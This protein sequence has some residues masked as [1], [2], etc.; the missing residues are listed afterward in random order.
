MLLVPKFREGPVIPWTPLSNLELDTCNA[1]ASTTSETL[2]KGSITIKHG[3]IG[4]WA[5]AFRRNGC[6]LCSR[7]HNHKQHSHTTGSFDHPVTVIFNREA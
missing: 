5:C 2:G 4:S 3:P 6:L 1:Q 7:T